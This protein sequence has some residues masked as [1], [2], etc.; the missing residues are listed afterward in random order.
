[1][2]GSAGARGPVLIAAPKTVLDDIVSRLAEPLAGETVRLASDDAALGAVLAQEAA[3]QDS[4][5][6]S[7]NAEGLN[8]HGLSAEGL[9]AE[10]SNAHGLGAAPPEVV[11]LMRGRDFSARAYQ[12]LTT[13]P[14]VRWLHV[15]GSGAEHLPAWDPERLTVTNAAHALAPFHAETV[16]GAIW[17]MN[18]GL[19]SHAQAQSSRRWRRRRFRSLAGQTLLVVGFGAVGARVGRLARGFGMR[20]IGLRR[21]GAPHPDADEIR[22]AEALFDSLGEADIVS[23]QPRFTERLRGL[24]DARAFAAMKRGALF[25]NTSRGGLVVEEDLIAALSIGQLGGAYL[26][27]AQTEPLPPESRLWAAPNL[28]LTA[29]CA[30]AV[31]DW[32]LRLADAFGENL[33]LWRR[34][35][36]LRGVMAPDPA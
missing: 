22:P 36:A 14:S 28:M 24:F 33:G 29:H 10:V 26:D 27:V 7:L 1:M 18:F 34:G 12:A 6:E 13:A 8:A 19:A 23:A 4:A 15:A 3:A 35:A 9:S 17:A 16:M 11:F 21:S 20:V 2:T 30:D 5:P 31:E 25:V 32:P